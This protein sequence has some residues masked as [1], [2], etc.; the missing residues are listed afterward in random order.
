MTPE[1]ALR[2]SKKGGGRKKKWYQSEG[3]DTEGVAP[4]KALRFRV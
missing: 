2:C 1:K 3:S 4:R